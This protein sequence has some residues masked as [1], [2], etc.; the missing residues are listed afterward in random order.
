MRIQFPDLSRPKSAAKLLSRYSPKVNLASAQEAIARAAGYRDWHELRNAQPA[1]QSVFDFEAAGQI[2]VGV[3]DALG[4]SYSDV[5]YAV[6]KSRLLG[7]SPWRLD[8]HL[9]LTTKVWRERIFGTPARGKPGTVVKVRAHGEARPAYLSR[10]GRPTH[11]LYETGPGICADFEAVAPRLPLAD[12]VPARFW[13][14]YGHWTLCDSS[15]VIFARDYLPMW[16]IAEGKVERLDP[17]LWIEGIE[18]MKVYSSQL[19]TVIW[20]RGLARELAL[21]HLRRHRI[22]ELPRLV[23]AMLHLIGDV[24]PTIHRSVER[25]RLQLGGGGPPP[26]F[27]RVRTDMR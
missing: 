12:F 26:D 4:L 17:W 18:D 8:D 23:D 20:A 2:V 27:A 15:E 22:F 21:S 10:A 9:A 7:A 14:P 1:S 16:R 25:L 5:Q 24:E 6:A 3:G 19:G 13:L 11:V